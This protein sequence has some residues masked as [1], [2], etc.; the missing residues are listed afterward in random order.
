MLYWLCQI[1]GAYVFGYALDSTL[2]RRKLRAYACLAALLV[3]T[4]ANW[5]G[6]YAFQA[7]YVR[8]TDSDKDA[9]EHRNMDW[10]SPGF[11]GPF[12]LYMAY[13]FFDAAWQTSVYWLMGAMSNN[14]RKLANFA[15]FYKGVQSAGN[16]IGASLD[17]DVLPYMTQ[18]A[19][20]WGL[21]LGNLLIA[22]PV[23]FTKVKGESPIKRHSW[24]ARLTV[25]DSTPLEED[26]KF[27]DESVEEVKAAEE[28]RNMTEKEAA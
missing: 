17:A 2:L 14:S 6:G 20:N 22:A 18:F 26:L 8:D 11:A 19:I 12:V 21:L 27:S 4:L 9:V 10:S 16:A 5:G 24:G 1:F 15:G 28:R 23:I 13:G 3:L 25:R 7:G